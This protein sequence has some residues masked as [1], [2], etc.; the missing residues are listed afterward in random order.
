MT[1]ST[2]LPLALSMGEPAG[3]G[4]EITLKAWLKRDDDGIPPFFII[5]DAGHLAVDA[6][7]LDL[8]VPLVRIAEPAAAIAAFA[9]GLPVLHRPLPH[10]P[11]PGRPQAAT[12]PSVAPPAAPPPPHA[13]STSRAA[14]TRKNRTNLRMVSFSLSL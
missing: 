6:A 2:P 5:A 1:A 11:V 9:R 13:A 14:R 8:G 7:A 12:A 4:A 10:M 3:I